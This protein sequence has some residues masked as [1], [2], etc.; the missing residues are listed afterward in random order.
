M[1]GQNGIFFY[2]IMGDYIGHRGGRSGVGRNDR[3]RS[4]IVSSIKI[5]G[6]GEVNR[7]L[8]ASL[9]CGTDT[10]VW[11]RTVLSEWFTGE[12]GGCQY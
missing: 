3:E 8:P 1:V 2:A 12:V 4:E 9:H 5:I 7:D 6:E 10:V 11:D